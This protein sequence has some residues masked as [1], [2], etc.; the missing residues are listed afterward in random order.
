MCSYPSPA[1]A[2]F[3]IVVKLFLAKISQS[4]KNI[5]PDWA[6]WNRYCQHYF[7]QVKIIIQLLSDKLQ[8][9]VDAAFWRI[10]MLIGR[11]RLRQSN[12]LK[13]ADISRFPL[14][15]DYGCKQIRTQLIL[16]PNYTFTNVC[17]N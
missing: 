2:K 16:W 13:N 14:R 15:P 4:E 9:R 11:M 6:K 12:N 10:L 7:D 3:L 8:V 17:L 1:C 5:S